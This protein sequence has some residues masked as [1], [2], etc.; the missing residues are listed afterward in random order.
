MNENYGVA[1]FVLGL[2]AIILNWF[3]LVGLICG[4]IGIILA[5]KQKTLGNTGL[6]KAGFVLSIIGTVFASVWN[7]FFIIGAL[8][9]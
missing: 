5:G 7:F 4:I 3:P 6:A 1:S 9:I 2:I 8:T